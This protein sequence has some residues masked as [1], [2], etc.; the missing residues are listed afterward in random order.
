MGEFSK[1]PPTVDEEDWNAIVDH[2]LEKSCAFIVRKKDTTY[3]AIYGS[4]A[5][6]AGKI[7]VGS[8]ST[9][10]LVTFQAVETT[11]SENQKIFVKHGDYTF[12]AKWSPAKKLR[13]HGEGKGTR[14]LPGG[15]FDAIDPSNLALF[16]IVWRDA[17]GIDHDASFD[18][19][20]FSQA[21]R[22]NFIPASLNRTGKVIWRLDPTKG[23]DINIIYDPSTERGYVSRNTFAGRPALMTYAL[24]EVIRAAKFFPLDIGER[25]GFEG[26]IGIPLEQQ[27]VTYIE[28]SILR[29]RNRPSDS[30]EQAQVR[31]YGPSETYAALKVRTTYGWGGAGGV[32]FETDINKIDVAHPM[33]DHQGVVWNYFKLVADFSTGKYVRFNYKGNEYDLSA[34][35]IA[36]STPIIAHEC[37]EVSV[38]PAGWTLP[39]LFWITDLIV[40]TEES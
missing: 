32:D 7:L 2:A 23:L 15:S 17:K 40:T 33:F 28:I 18:P 19:N 9:D 38:S 16:D 13:L 12:S 11:A 35:S 5:D 27:R 6:Q 3:E 10:A 21:L 39:Y 26:Y 4:G 36:T 25:L 1:Y 24:T 30:V 22:E 14:L 20:V 29:Y 8:Q 34:Y 37:Y 31:I